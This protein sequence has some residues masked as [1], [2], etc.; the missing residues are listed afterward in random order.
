MTLTDAARRWAE[1][2]LDAPVVSAT[3]LTGGVASRMLLLRTAHGRDAVLRQMVTEPYRRF[4]EGLLTRE[5]GIQ[6][7]LSDT[8]LPVPRTLA[9]D[10]RG[11][12]TGDPSL[13][14]T[15]LRGAI[16]FQCPSDDRLE[17]LA[18]L[19]LRIHRIVPPRGEWPRV[20]QSWATAPK[21]V[22]P[23]WS[24]DDA[25]YREAFARLREPAPR[26]DA[27][28][29][30]R[31]FHP[32]NVLWQG[33]EVSGI[34]DWV[35]TSTGPADLD[36]AHCVSNLAALHGVDVALAFRRAYVDRGGDVAA[37]ADDAAYWQL[38]D[39][40]GFLPD[41]TGRESGAQAPVV[42]AVWAAHGRPDLTVEVAR[43]RREDL[44][45][46]VLSR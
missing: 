4:A 40:V 14:M 21:L 3:R 23:P 24:R 36:V 27:T 5:C 13:L 10:A 15:R 31:D 29:L 25:A 1:S 33:G 2:V 38:L 20:Y 19:L 37:D 46:A 8:D 16:D 12:V 34:V 32:G 43:R 35:E 45:L 11:Q 26:Y 7:M 41:G 6:G 18:E 30:H 22:V 28:F 9:L 17:S 39:L 44:L 42:E